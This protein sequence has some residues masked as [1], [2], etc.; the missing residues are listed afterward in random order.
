MKTYKV[1]KSK[2][3][4][5]GVYAADNIKAGTKI[6]YYKG[7]IVGETTSGNYSFIYNKNLAYGYI[8]AKLDFDVSNS[9]FEIEVAK[10]K[11]KASI[12]KFLLKDMEVILS[13]PTLFMNQSG[14]SVAPTVKGEN[15]KL[16][17][18]LV[19]H[20]DLDLP[21]GV[22]KLKF[23]GG[24]GGHNGLKDIMQSLSGKK[25]FKRLRIGIGHPGDTKKVNSFVVKKGSSSERKNKLLAMHNALEVFELVAFDD[26]E[27][28]LTQL[29]SK[30]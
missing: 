2:I 30:K 22:S 13:I 3:D 10:K 28:A 26:W 5:L 15:I 24:D 16:K 23:S 7:K 9:V 1:K 19:V 27:K 14:K 6:I 20:D 21:P 11:Y 17:N 12:G 18:L 4:N 25:D 8:D 29:H